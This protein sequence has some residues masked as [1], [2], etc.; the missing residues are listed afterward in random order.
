MA[1]AVLH[2]STF[3][4][5]D[6]DTHFCNKVKQTAG[7]R[8]G[9]GIRG[10]EGGE[11]ANLPCFNWDVFFLLVLLPLNVFAAL[12]LIT[13]VKRLSFLVSASNSQLVT[14]ISLCTLLKYSDLHDQ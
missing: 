6:I 7:V 9:I 4:P 2:N 3:Y 10:W 1:D 14:V 11:A 12:F 13:P 5:P 8:V